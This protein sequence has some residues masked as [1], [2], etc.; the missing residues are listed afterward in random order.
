[1]DG[2]ASFTACG[3]VLDV[4]VVGALFIG[5]CMEIGPPSLGE[6]DVS[7]DVVGVGGSG[8]TCTLSSV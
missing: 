8:L 4:V 2:C 7:L 3:S 5:E 1:M 6:G